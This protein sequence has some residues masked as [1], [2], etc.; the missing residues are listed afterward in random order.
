MGQVIERMEA[1]A[2]R[3]QQLEAE[4]LAEKRERERLQK[5][6]ANQAITIS[7]QGDALHV[8]A[9]STLTDMVDE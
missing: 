6:I 2:K 4:I 3:C 9:A 8:L 5:V 1:L 7:E